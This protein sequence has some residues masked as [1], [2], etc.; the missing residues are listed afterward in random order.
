MRF[1]VNTVLVRVSHSEC[2]LSNPAYPHLRDSVSESG[3]S[4]KRF[5]NVRATRKKPVVND[6]SSGEVRLNE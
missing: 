4:G 6:I 3:H 5:L 2:T 1:M